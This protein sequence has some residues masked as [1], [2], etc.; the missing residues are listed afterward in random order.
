MDKKINS[1]K[2]LDLNKR[3]ASRREL[4]KKQCPSNHCASITNKNF[5]NLESI[6]Y[7]TIK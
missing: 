2:M 3:T 5:K 4:M 6:V 7:S 1:V